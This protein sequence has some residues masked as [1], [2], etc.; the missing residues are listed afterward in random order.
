[1]ITK[2]TLDQAG[3]VLLPKRLRQEL[4]LGPGDSMQLESKG[5][6]ITLRP[7]R[8][9]ALLKKERG[10]WVYQGEQT[11]ASIP[12]VIDRERE[13]RLRELMG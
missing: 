6:E 10:V 13:K 1:M 12:D 9:K 2:L 11:D 4:R 7:V 3:R 5:E 8:P